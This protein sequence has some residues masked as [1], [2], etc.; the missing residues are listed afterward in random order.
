MTLQW[1]EFRILVWLCGKKNYFQDRW[2]HKIPRHVE[3]VLLIR[4][5][6][7]VR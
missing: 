7:S 2:L 3:R 6:L 5:K 1:E 4:T